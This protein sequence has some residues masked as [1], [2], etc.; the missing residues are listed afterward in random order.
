MNQEVKTPFGPKKSK[1]QLTKEFNILFDPLNPH[2]K[3]HVLAAPPRYQLLILKS[4]A[5]LNTRSQSIRAKCLQCSSFD[6][7]EIRDCS[8]TYC[9][10]HAH[11][12]YQ[13]KTDP[14]IDNNEESNDTIED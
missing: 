6:I 13:S 4:I 2:E 10:I 1:E 14:D 7:L 8:V 9:A 3:R 11:R 5:R 12:P